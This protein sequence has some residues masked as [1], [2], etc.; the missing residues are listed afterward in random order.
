MWPGDLHRRLICQKTRN[1]NQHREHLDKALLFLVETDKLSVHTI[2]II[3]IYIQVY[4]NTES[5]QNISPKPE[6]YAFIYIYMPAGV[7]GVR[8]RH[9]PLPRCAAPTA[10]ATFPNRLSVGPCVTSSRQT[11]T[12]C[13]AQICCCRVYC[14]YDVCAPGCGLCG[15]VLWL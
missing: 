6:I 11:C 9:V 1:S 10:R 2:A 7:D 3:Q 4:T 8:M 13:R 5:E 14:V 12:Q 15:R